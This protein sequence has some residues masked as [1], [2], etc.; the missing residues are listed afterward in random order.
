M[1]LSWP[2]PVA[3]SDGIFPDVAVTHFNSPPP[4][5]NSDDIKTHATV[6]PRGLPFA[7]AANYFDRMQ[8]TPPTPSQDDS[9]GVQ[10]SLQCQTAGDAQLCAKL[11]DHFDAETRPPSPGLDLAGREDAQLEPP[12]RHVDNMCGICHDHW[13]IGFNPHSLR[14]CRRCH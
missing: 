10:I 2:G 9:D 5:R 12:T 3:A 7:A 1:G 4:L 11:V 13:R 6:L 14:V 8:V